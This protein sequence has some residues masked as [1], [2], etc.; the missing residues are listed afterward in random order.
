MQDLVNRKMGTEQQVCLPVMN[1]DERWLNYYTPKKINS[2]SVLQTPKQFIP[3][4]QVGNKIQAMK[5]IE[6][7]RE[8]DKLAKMTPPKPKPINRWKM[9]DMQS[10]PWKKRELRKKEEGPTF[11]NTKEITK[12]PSFDL[13]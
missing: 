1:L 3:Y 6:I 4:Q 12:E 5:N 7:Q 8:K 9:V 10:G 13:Q 2:K 11:T